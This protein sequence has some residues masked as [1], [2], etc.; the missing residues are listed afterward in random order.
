MMLLPWFAL[1][2]AVVPSPQQRPCPPALGQGV[3]CS[4]LKDDQGAWI[5]FARPKA[6]N[7]TLIVHAH[8]GPRLGAP[9]ADDPDEDLVRFS[10]LVRAG[11]AWAGTS[12]RRG[13]YGVR[14][15]AA[16]T[17][18]AR[19]LYWSVYGR[20]GMTLLHGQSWGGNVAAKLAETGVLD[21]E[22]KPLY[23]GVMITNGVLAGGTKAYQF[24]VDL[25]A[26]YQFYCRNLP[27]ADEPAY[28]I[29]QGLPLNSKLTRKE[30]AARVDECTGVDTPAAARSAG[31]VARLRDILAV[32]RISE[33]QLVQQLAYT[34]FTFR[35]IVMLRLGGRNPFDN[36]G[37]R[38]SGSA[39]DAALNTNIPRFRADP[40]AVSALAFDSDLAG[41]IVLPTIT[42]HANGDPV[43]PAEGDAV[44]ARTVA[45][46]GNA[47]LLLSLRTSEDNHSKMS[48][49]EYVAVADALT[50]WVRSGRRPA[51][52]DVF[53]RCDGLA[54]GKQGCAFVP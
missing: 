6:G 35:D 43:I 22:G 12:Y 20:P 52:S 19:A 9:Q 31:Q 41:R 29:W 18:R 33:G 47:R 15:A 5:L 46:A 7:G 53:R 40:D 13:G 39:D 21:D 8:G 48:D 45:A 27:K 4:T 37:S 11:Y 42:M 51:P 1:A 2:A 36:S 38:Y 25:R 44:Y 10:A 23:N 14:M 34:S 26:V 17:D 32:T 30:L 16:D 3:E 54:H 28:P 50:D 24:R 49:A